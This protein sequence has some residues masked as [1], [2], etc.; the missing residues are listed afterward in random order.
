MTTD[1]HSDSDVDSP[2]KTVFITYDCGA[3]VLINVS[4]TFLHSLP[5]V[6]PSTKR[7][8]FSFVK[9]APSLKYCKKHG[10]LKDCISQFGDQELQHLFLKYLKK[11]FTCY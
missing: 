3:T 5:W 4:E 10:T 7:R 1:E 11:A 6:L 2:P 8:S 9:H